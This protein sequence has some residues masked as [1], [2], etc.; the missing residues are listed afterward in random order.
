MSRYFTRRT[1]PKATHYVE[2]D[3]Y[4]DPPRDRDL[5]VPEHRATDTGLLDHRG[6]RIMRAPNPCGFVW[7]KS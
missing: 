7:S 2:D 3:H 6:D 1:A 5:F 4:G